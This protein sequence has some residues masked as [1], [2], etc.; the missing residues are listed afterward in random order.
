MSVVRFVIDD[1]MGLWREGDLAD[2]LGPESDP[3]LVPIYL[4]RLHER[5][6][7]IGLEESLARA[8]TV[9]VES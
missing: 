4:L 8:V 1:P 9:E 2:W 6:E 7:V 3:E 5:D